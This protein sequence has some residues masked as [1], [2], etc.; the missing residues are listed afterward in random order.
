MVMMSFLTETMSFWIDSLKKGIKSEIA[1]IHPH[2][3]PRK[4]FMKRLSKGVSS[5]F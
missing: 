1:A 2:D 5:S 4:V 3:C